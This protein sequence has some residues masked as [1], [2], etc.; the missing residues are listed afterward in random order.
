VATLE[1]Q[2]DDLYQGQLQDFVPRRNALAKSLSGAERKHVA[3]LQKPSALA[4]AVNHTYWRARA[5]YEELLSRG[6]RLRAAQV[7][8]LKGRS[9]DVRA[10]TAEHREAVSRAVAAASR[11]A[12]AAGLKPSSADLQR[13][14]EAVSLQDALPEAHGRFTKPV[15]LAGFEA[16]S[17][18]AIA[19]PPAAA[20]G[21][22]LKE[23]GDGS[24][25]RARE[26]AEAE[27]KEREKA[28][29]HAEARVERAE[30]E[31]QRARA[32]WEDARKD[33]EEARR[34]LADLT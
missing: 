9:A 7:S 23:T 27:R 17:G 26:R 33:L 21:S 32:Q 6:K 16:L 1:A 14:F 5:A 13:M 3:S 11:L 15:Q 10:A 8:A 34:K 22:R 31:E 20:A 19:P 24:A 28:V 18:I 30:A 29:K 4:W 25:R 2:I 12:D